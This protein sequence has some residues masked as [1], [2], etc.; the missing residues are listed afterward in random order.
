MHKDIKKFRNMKKLLNQN[1]SYLEDVNSSGD[2]E[3][4]K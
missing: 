4:K 3:Y 2:E 1:L